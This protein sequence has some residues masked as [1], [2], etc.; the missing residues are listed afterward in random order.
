MGHNVFH[1]YSPV[2]KTPFI[3]KMTINWLCIFPL[4]LH[5]FRKIYHEPDRHQ[6]NI[7]CVLF[8]TLVLLLHECADHSVHVGLKL[9]AEYSTI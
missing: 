4:R 8:C 3:P 6:G 5:S 2:H 9:F 1:P 7:F